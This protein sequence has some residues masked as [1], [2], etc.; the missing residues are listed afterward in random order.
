MGLRFVR[1]LSLVAASGGH[2][3]LRCAG[4][5]VSWPLPLRGTGSR[6][7]GSKPC[8]PPSSAMPLLQLAPS[9]V[10]PSA[11]PWPPRGQRQLSILLLHQQ[12]LTALITPSLKIAPLEKHALRVPLFSPG[13]LPAGSSSWPRSRV[14]KRG[15]RAAACCYK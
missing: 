8:S 7:A 1:G 9:S 10:L 5:S 4:L 3:S 11:P 12:H 2:S 13:L 6:C 14:S 15:P